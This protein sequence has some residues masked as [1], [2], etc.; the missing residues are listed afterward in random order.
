M[1]GQVN[2]GR[3]FTL[4]EAMVSVA[5]LAIILAVAMPAYT[6]YQEKNRLKGAA[7]SVYAL[8]QYA[9]SES[10]KLDRDLNVIVSDGSSWCMGISNNTSCTCS[11]AGSCTYG[12]SG[13]EQTVVGSGYPG[14]S[15][16]NSQSYIAFKSPSGMSTGFNDTL[17]LTSPK[18]YKLSVVHSVRGAS[19]ICNTS[20]MGGYPAC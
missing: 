11:T 14:I 17:T 18:G 2:L 13:Q 6:D 1:L 9:R 16:D 10:I 8:L 4:I 3:G 20:N 12:P 7:E 5:I 19:R 15:L